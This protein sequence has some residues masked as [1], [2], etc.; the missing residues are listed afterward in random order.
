MRYDR[1]GLL[2]F[3]T[4]PLGGIFSDVIYRKLGPSRGL[5]GKVCK[6]SMFFST[7]HVAD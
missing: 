5:Q 6:S 4:R 1:F 2:N 3:I 7:S